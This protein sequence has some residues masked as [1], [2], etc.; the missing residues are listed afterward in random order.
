MTGALRRSAHGDDEQ[1]GVCV[2]ADK[3]YSVHMV[4]NRKS[5]VQLAA[6]WINERYVGSLSACASIDPG[7]GSY[8]IVLFGS[9]EDRSHEIKSALSKAGFRNIVVVNVRKCN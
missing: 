6:G 1:F 2:F 7:S 8:H 4:T 9:S 3:G 5:I